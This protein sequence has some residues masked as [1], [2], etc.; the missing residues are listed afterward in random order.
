[1]TP[2]RI[3]GAGIAGALALTTVLVAPPAQ[4]DDRAVAVG[5]AWLVRQLDDGVVHNDQYDFDDVGLTIDTALALAAIDAPAAQ[6]DRIETGLAPLVDGYTGGGDYG[7]SA[8][9]ALV[10]AQLLG[11]DPTTYG[12]VDLVE[13]TEARVLDAPAGRLADVDSPFG[14]FVNVVSQSLGARGLSDAG[15]PDAAAVEAFLLE[16]Q[17][18][19]GFFRLSLTADKA[20]PEQGCVTGA[21][22]SEPDVDATAITV[23]NLLEI[24]TPSPAVTTAIADAVGWLQ[25]TQAADGSFSGTG[26]GGPNANSTGLAGWAL[27]ESALP[28][29]EADAAAAAVWVRRVQAVNN[30]RCTSALVGEQGG[31]A[32]DPAAF[33]T[34]LESGIPAETQDQWRRATTQALPSQQWA[35]E[36]DGARAVGGGTTAYVAAGSVR[37]VTATG[38]APG[39]RVCAWTS[40]TQSQRPSA[41]DGTVVDPGP[42]ARLRR[43]ARRHRHRLAGR[44]RPGDVPGARRPDPPG[45]ARA[46]RRCAR[47]ARSGS[48]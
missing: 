12:G 10:A 40:T 21:E 30:G 7:G 44:R 5:N 15:S 29:T 11:A 34:G 27:G 39:D 32:L 28:G 36:P 22:G 4:A 2:M 48:R 26:T 3:V 31:I 8:A 6:L 33:A 9:K 35:P 18:D 43:V 23:L 24:D 45:R 19:A 1:M 25:D 17:C 41:A 14:D 13:L 46:R 42:D 16:Q 38:V 47:A 37:T 20:A